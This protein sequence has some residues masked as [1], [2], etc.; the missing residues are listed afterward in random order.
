MPSILFL[1]RKTKGKV[2]GEEGRLAL[3]NMSDLMLPRTLAP[4]PRGFA[5]PTHPPGAMPFTV[6][7][8]AP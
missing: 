2:E 5:E 4:Q 3:A 7:P 6:M 1:I 8:R